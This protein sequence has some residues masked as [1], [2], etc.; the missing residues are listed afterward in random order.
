MIEF[1]FPAAVASLAA[2]ALGMF[3]YSPAFLGRQ[4]MREVGITQ[5]DMKNPKNG[6]TMPLG[7]GL[8][9]LSQ[10]IRMFFLTWAIFFVAPIGLG[11][12]LLV[13]LAVWVG[14]LAVSDL[15]SVLWEMKSWRLFFINTSYNL[16]IMLIATV[17][18]FYL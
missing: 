8:G 11:E 9:L 12:A 7:M 15:G 3:W 17:I 13:G 18:I 14:F 16:V 5:D 6:V 2:M 10:F 1:I 4:W